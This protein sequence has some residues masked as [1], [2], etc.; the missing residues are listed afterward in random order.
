MWARGIVKMDG[1]W[2][3]AE[4]RLYIDWLKE[5]ALSWQ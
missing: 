4:R 1:S 5:C 2:L 3:L